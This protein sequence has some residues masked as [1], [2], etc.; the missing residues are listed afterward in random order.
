MSG[1]GRE[2]FEALYRVARTVNSS[3][4]IM[5]VLQTI[6]VAT[7]E[8]LNAKA[9]SLRL[10]APDGKHLLFGTSHGL[11]TNYRLKGPVLLAQSEVDRQAL[12]AGA[13]VTVD[14]APNDPRLQYPQRARDEGIA[15]M[16]VAPLHVQSQ[17]IGV[18]R[19][20]T[21]ESH[22]FDAEE[23]ELA[24]AIASLSAIAIENSRLY[25]R[26]NRNYQAAVALTQREFD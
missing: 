2:S 26:L 9:C 23:R 19:V 22:A 25:E 3:L 18:L 1:S 14:D 11:S 10:L 15:S 4:D 6:V 17:P 24:Q 5:E 21:A 12:E 7:T 13:P 20:Y 8:A 16:L